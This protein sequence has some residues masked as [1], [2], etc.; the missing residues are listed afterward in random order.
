MPTQQ[1]GGVSTDRVVPEEGGLN[2]KVIP[3]DLCQSNRIH[4]T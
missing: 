1:E 2:R 4:W 3:L